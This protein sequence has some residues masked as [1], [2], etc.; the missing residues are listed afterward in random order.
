ML[1]LTLRRISSL[2]ACLL[3]ANSAWATTTTQTMNVSGQGSDYIFVFRGNDPAFYDAL[4]AY[5][6][7]GWTAVCHSSQACAGTYYTISAAVQVD[8]Q[9]L[10]LYV[11]D[12]NGNPA[13]PDSGA[14]YYFTDEPYPPAPPRLPAPGTGGTSLLPPASPP[15]HRRTAPRSQGEPARRAPATAPSRWRRPA[16]RR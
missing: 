11:V 2:L 15:H 12:A 5:N 6:P 4:V 9:S 3:F 10:Y 7:V 1:L 16:P 8:T 14:W 13:T